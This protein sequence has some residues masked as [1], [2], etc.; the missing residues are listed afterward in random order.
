M[1][2]TRAVQEHEP[3]GGP[4]VVDGLHP[5][6][7][8]GG[9]HLQDAPPPGPRDHAQLQLDTWHHGGV[10]TLIKICHFMR[11]KLF[12]RLA[13]TALWNTCGKISI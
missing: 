11:Q 8:R 9:R 13:V 6:Q 1:I 2:Q 10:C 3:G 7:L 5:L 4:G 12:V